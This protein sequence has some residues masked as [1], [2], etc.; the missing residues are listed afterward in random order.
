M[1]LY[2]RLK[3]ALGGLLALGLAACSSP[4]PAASSSEASSTSSKG[5]ETALA[6]PLKVLCPQ[7]APALATLGL[8]VD[9]ADVEYVEGQDLLVSELSKKE[10]DY[11]MIVAPINLGVKTWKE[12]E[13]YQL[14]GVLTW[15]N[16]YVVSA[17]ETWNAP[18]KKIALFGEGAV[19][20]L[21]FDE[22]YPDLQATSE[23][24]PSVAE[25][26]TALVSGKVDAA[27]L[28]QP[29][30]AGAVA[31]AKENGTEL[32]VQA[33]L[34]QRWQEKHET[35]QKGY[36]Q[37]ALFV[38]KDHAKDYQNAIDKMADY[39]KTADESK[40]EEDVDLLTPDKLGVPNAKLAAKTWAQQNIHFEKAADVEEDITK[41]LDV[42]GM[43]LPEG[44][45]VK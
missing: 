26:S 25:A 32:K 8:E 34:Q 41:F 11:D 42:F 40:I 16:L 13:A 28:A 18:D 31:K 29:A 1:S 36:P 43:K 27:L 30:A 22:V 21:V 10:G 37:A 44:L 6:E 3:P 33:D 24:Y 23:Y 9:D 2:H 14:E 7:G 15:G 5:S 20:G 45:L 17:D 38:K 39:L 35:S 19:P 12:A 4:A